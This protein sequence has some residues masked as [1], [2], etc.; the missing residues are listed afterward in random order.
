MS[1]DLRKSALPVLL[2]RTSAK[3]LP[4]LLVD[5]DVKMPATRGGGLQLPRLRDYSYKSCA[6]QKAGAT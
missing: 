5:A 4:N 2:A 1:E 6:P 3:R